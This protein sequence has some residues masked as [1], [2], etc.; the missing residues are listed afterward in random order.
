[1]RH[2]PHW[3]LVAVG[4]AACSGGG[5][6]GGG[7]GGA[8]GSAG[9][10]IGPQLACEAGDLDLAAAT[11]PGLSVVALGTL[12]VDR[13]ITVGGEPAFGSAPVSICVPPDA[14]SLAL[15]GDPVA[16]VLPVSWIG[17]GLGELVDTSSA[18]S[19]IRS[20]TPELS[21]PK[22]P[23]VALHAGR[24]TFVLAAEAPLNAGPAIAIRRGTRGAS[25]IFSVNLVLVDGSGIDASNAEGFINASQFFDQVYAQAKVEVKGVGVARVTDVALAVVSENALGTL[26]AAP[27]VAE[28]E[29]PVIDGALNLY[30]VREILSS[31]QAGTLLGRSLGNPGVPS[32]I[33]KRGVV[34]SVDAHRLGGAID[35]PAMWIT[36]AHEIGHW[37]GLRH[38]TERWGTPQDFVA[39]TPECTVQNDFDK[40]GLVD[41]S[42]CAGRG[43]ENLMFWTYDLSNPP[44]VLVPGQAFV[45]HSALTMNPG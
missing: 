12:A 42:E 28:P 1:M 27:L 3:L 8:G 18:Q 43:A 35:F 23:D 24:H 44:T 6:G 32:L 4:L 41:S 39:D 2:L 22:S 30:F 19:L 14:V 45:L 21:L 13:P 17:S 9:I 38:T 20:V 40:N 26:A 29:A 16:E 5:G 31:D 11:G 15:Y 37:H 25:G 34:L 33:P 10:P 36:V 7:G